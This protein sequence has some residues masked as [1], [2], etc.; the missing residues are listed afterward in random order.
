MVMNISCKLEK[1]SYNIFFV[2]AVMVKTLYTLQRWRN[3]A[4][5]I[6]YDSYNV[7]MTEF[8]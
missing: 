7:S 3:E 4:K 1:S 6:S 5:S 8:D 2:I